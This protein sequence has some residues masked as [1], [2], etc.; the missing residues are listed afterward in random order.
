[1]GKL[2]TTPFSVLCVDG[3]VGVCVF[4]T[5]DEPRKHRLSMNTTLTLVFWGDIPRSKYQT[6]STGS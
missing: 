4:V 3:E 5:Q 1:M 6:P 2:D